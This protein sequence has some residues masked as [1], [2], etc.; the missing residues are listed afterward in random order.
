[1]QS[2]RILIGALLTFGVM[3][4]AHQFTYLPL[5]GRTFQLTVKRPVVSGDSLLVDVENLGKT[6]VY[7]S[8]GTIL[9]KI[10]ESGTMLALRHL[11]SNN[12]IG[13]GPKRLV[14]DIMIFSNSSEE[15]I[16][17]WAENGNASVQ[18]VFSQFDDRIR[19]FKWYLDHQEVK[20][21]LSARVARCSSANPQRSDNP[22]RD[23]MRCMS[24]FG[25]MHVPST[26]EAEALRD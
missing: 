17:R 14:F 19:G 23:A 13:P 26:V 4:L 16:N 10:P 2:Y 24:L 11:R 7:F 3:L 22:Q 1:M 25:A 18:L 5:I 20:T 9:M 6:P 8:E 12:P 15:Q 21:I